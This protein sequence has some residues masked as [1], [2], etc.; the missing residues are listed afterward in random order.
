[1]KKKIGPDSE[2]LVQ[3]NRFLSSRAEILKTSATSISIYRIRSCSDAVGPTN[4]ENQEPTNCSIKTHVKRASRV[5]LML[6]NSFWQTQIG[7]CERHNNMLANC[8][9]QI[10]LVSILANISPTVCQH[11]VVSFTHANLSLPTRVGQY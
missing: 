6:A 9:R 4:R 7:V 1:M 10:E 2:N 5:K 11:V 3:C 8:W